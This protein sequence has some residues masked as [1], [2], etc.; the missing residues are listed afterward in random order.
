[1]K[2]TLLISA[3]VILLCA[4]FMQVNE[5]LLP[6][7][8]NWPKAAYPFEKNA[9]SKAGVNLGRRLFYDPILS[10]NS[11]I[12]C[13]SCHSPYN[14]FTHVDHALSHGIHDSIGT[15][16][17]PALMNLAWHKTFMWDGS[18]NNLD[19]QALAPITHPLEMGEK[20]PHVLQKLQSQTSYRQQ[21]YAA[22]RDSNISADNTFKA[23]SQFLLTLISYHSKYDSVSQKLSRFSPQEENGYRLFRK[24]CNHCHTEPLFTNDEF[25]NNGLRPDETLKDEGRKKITGKESDAYCFKVPSLRNIAYSPPYMHDGRFKTLATVLKHYSEGIQPSKTLHPSLKNGIKLRNNE[26]VD[27]VAFLLCLSDKAF[28]L[29]ANLHFPRQTP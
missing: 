27:L 12:S 21:F 4:A 11:S 24:H 16:N 23:L 9:L 22:Y 25:A 13:A 8:K 19:Q 1:L 18:I 17:S 28:I 29:N 14:A 6:V 2:K 3:A 20:M 5:V 10:A 15:R 7:P 26:Q